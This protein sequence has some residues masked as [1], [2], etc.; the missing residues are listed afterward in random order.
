MKKLK[1]LLYGIS[2]ERIVGA[3]SISIQAVEFD[4][5]KIKPGSL[6]VA[7]NGYN[8]DGH[9]YIDNAEQQGAVAIICEQLPKNFKA[10][11]VYVQVED[12]SKALGQ[13]S[14][15]FYDHPSQKLK[16]IGIT[17]TNGKTT[18]ASLLYG[19]FEALG[20]PCGLISTVKMAYLNQERPATHTT[21]N[22]VEINQFLAEL[23][24]KGVTHCFMEVSSHGIAQGRIEGLTFTGGIFTNLTHE[25][26]DYHGD[27][28]TYRDT[29]K[30][31]FDLLPPQAFALTNLDDKN[32]EYMLQNTKAKTLTYALKHHADYKVH[33]LECELTG[34]LLKIQGQEV[35]TNLVGEFNA[36]NLIAVYAA[37][38][39]LAIPS[40]AILKQISLLKPTRGRFEIL[41]TQENITI[42]VDYAHSPDALENVLQTIN[43]IR[44][45]NEKLITI[46]G[47]GGNR[48]KEKRPIMG[49]KAAALSDQVIFTS[50]NPRGEDP[51]IIIEEMIKGVAAEDFKKVLKITLREEAISEAGNMARKGDI[52]LIAGKGHET[53]QEI[54][55][56]KYPFDDFQIAQQIFTKTQY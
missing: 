3:T 54:K 53:Y 22:A 23:V 5:R 49:N 26:L 16:L 36:Q 45:R 32:G 39:L 7:Q 4:S 50:D 10:E 46:V 2:I 18:V 40:L 24:N 41:Q 55:G 29:K 37:A 52:V 42:I 51:Q 21:P 48:D 56:K 43:K 12:A 28:K 25:H 6:F 44:T 11:V 20:H 27:F 34:M 47:C 8:T 31:F 9:L 35:W 30:H 33:L 14:S 1:D 38:E 17:G 15:N 13:L 19:L